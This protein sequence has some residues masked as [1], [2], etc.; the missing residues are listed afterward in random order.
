[1]ADGVG[2]RLH[3]IRT[4][5]TA[6]A[7]RGMPHADRAVAAATSA[8]DAQALKAAIGEKWKGQREG[9]RLLAKLAGAV[10]RLPPSS[11]LRI[12]RIRR[13]APRQGGRCDRRCAIEIQAATPA[14][15]RAPHPKMKIT[16]WRKDA[17]GA[18]S[19]RATGV[20]EDE[21]AAP[22]T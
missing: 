12:S 3:R 18:L 19:R 5:A 16:G 1:M 2:Q 7:R 11:R 4:V 21:A 6:L 9:G 14:R 13:P 15:D 17:S 8:R 20:V 22:A 10:R